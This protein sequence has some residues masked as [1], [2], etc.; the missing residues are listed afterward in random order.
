MQQKI[1]K[2]I[3]FYLYATIAQYTFIYKYTWI[4][5]YSNWNIIIDTVIICLS[6]GQFANIISSLP[7]NTV[8]VMSVLL[9]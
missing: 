8:E 7:S 1:P 9:K 6:F 5:R 3:V 4:T 2:N